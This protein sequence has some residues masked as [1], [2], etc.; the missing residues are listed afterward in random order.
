MDDYVGTIVYMKGIVLKVIVANNPN[1]VL[2]I[3]MQPLLVT[4]P[5]DIAELFVHVPH[6][7]MNYQIHHLDLK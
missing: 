2:F 6:R 1:E 3:Y 5:V 4:Y 7:V